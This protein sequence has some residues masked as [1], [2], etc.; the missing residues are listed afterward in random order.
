[1]KGNK[2]QAQQFPQCLS[3]LHKSLELDKTRAQ[4]DIMMIP[5][6]NF[7]C[8]HKHKPK[9]VGCLQTISFDDL[10]ANYDVLWKNI[11]LTPTLRFHDLKY[12]QIL[13][14]QWQL[15]KCQ[16][17]KKYFFNEAKRPKTLLSL[18]KITS[19]HK[20]TWNFWIKWQP[21]VYHFIGISVNVFKF[22]F[23]YLIGNQPNIH[24]H[25]KW[26]F[27]WILHSTKSIRTHFK[28]SKTNRQCDWFS[29]VTYRFYVEIDRHR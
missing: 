25:S 9:S 18:K 7:S 6:I 23:H 15:I 14:F 12:P 22:L 10:T 1:M 16:R 2:N 29:N 13:K 27:V 11:A 5:R 3:Y 8:K 26:N 17:N 4:T 24:A 19:L 20:C 28:H 21:S